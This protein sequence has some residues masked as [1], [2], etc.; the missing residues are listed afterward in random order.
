MRYI[1][2]PAFLLVALFVA[3]SAE[4]RTSAILL[5]CDT[6]FYTDTVSVCDSV[7]WI[8][9]NTYYHND[10]THTYTYIGA[11]SNGC[12]SVVTL[13]LKI[14]GD[15]PGLQT[16]GTIVKSSKGGD[17]YFWF[18]CDD[19]LKTPFANARTVVFDVK[20]PVA[21]I[22]HKEGCIDTSACTGWSTGIA[23]SSPINSEVFPNPV[24]DILAISLSTDEQVDFAVI[25]EQGRVHLKFTLYGKREHEIDVSKLKT[26]T[27]YL[28]NKYE[29][30]K[31]IKR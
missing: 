16:F 29:T 5:S 31:L 2:A 25:D 18:Y 6:V 1:L 26:G 13:Y 15:K 9:G 22:V 11:A 7:T 3:A 24:G 17:A 19:S 14:N 10:S 27:Y 23:K 30:I 20:R 21:V 12:D 28:R 4:A 8:D